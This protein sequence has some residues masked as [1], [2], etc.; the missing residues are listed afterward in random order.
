MRR[1]ED[2]KSMNL[3]PLLSQSRRISPNR[4]LGGSRQ[5]PLSGPV[6]TGVY[7]GDDPT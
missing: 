1:P 5:T 7:H 4:H 2:R 3:G 6:E